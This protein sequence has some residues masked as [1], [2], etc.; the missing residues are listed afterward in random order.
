MNDIEQLQIKINEH[1]GVITYH[2]GL[3]DEYNA[4][5]AAIEV[6]LERVALEELKAERIES[7]I[8]AI[9]EELDGLLDAAEAE[10][11]REALS[12]CK[13]GGCDE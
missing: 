1:L 6:E 9:K 8:T 12:G 13:D 5:I 10:I 3:V 2:Q 11:M 4:K 7:D